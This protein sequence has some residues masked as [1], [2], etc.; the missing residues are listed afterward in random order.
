MKPV[1]FT[2]FR[3]NASELCSEVEKGGAFLVLRHGRPI[4][5]IIPASS[6]RAEAPSW[7]KPGLRLTTKGVGLAAAIL[8]ERA[9][10]DIS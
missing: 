5:E 2:E 1:A 7:K 6:D 8:Q 9:R 4:A 10:E 3:N